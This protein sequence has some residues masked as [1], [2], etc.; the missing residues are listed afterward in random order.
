MLKQEQQEQAKNPVKTTTYNTRK[1]KVKK[2]FTLTVK[3]FILNEWQ[4]RHL[5]IRTKL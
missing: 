4:L 5:H 2:G 3:W 1:N